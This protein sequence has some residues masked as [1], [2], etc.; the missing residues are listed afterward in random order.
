MKTHFHCENTI[1]HNIHGRIHKIL[2]NFFAPLIFRLMRCMYGWCG[3]FEYFYLVR[4]RSKYTYMWN[5]STYFDMFVFVRGVSSLSTY[6]W[7][8]IS[9]VHPLHNHSYIYSSSSYHI[10]TPLFLNTHHFF[11]VCVS[12]G[13]FLIFIFF[14]YYFRVSIKQH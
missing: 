12:F 3:K 9:N 14:Y 4:Q 2:F 5:L 13:F 1:H 7:V 11:F 6:Y 8:Y 10:R